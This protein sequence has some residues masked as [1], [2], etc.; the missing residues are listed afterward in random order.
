MLKISYAG[1]F[2]LSPAISPQFTVE[3][4]A[5]VKNCEKFIK[6]PSFG[7]SRS[8]KVIDVDK[9]KNPVTSACLYLSATVLT[10]DEPI[11]AK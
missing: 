3:T 7:G 10:V 11:A 5:A 4:R 1:C 6:N 2:G 8:F 9:S